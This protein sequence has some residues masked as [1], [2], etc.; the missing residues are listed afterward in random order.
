MIINFVDKAE[1]GRTYCLDH[2]LLYAQEPNFDSDYCQTC[3]NS[4]GLSECLNIECYERSEGDGNGV[5][6]FFRFPRSRH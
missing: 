6:K 4:D 3:A 1:S 5:G 2:E